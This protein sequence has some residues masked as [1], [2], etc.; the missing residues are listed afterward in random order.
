V[1]AAG[2]GSGSFGRRAYD[3]RRIH[4]GDTLG[5]GEVGLQLGL[6]RQLFVE[7]ALQR[8]RLA[9]TRF[10]AGEP[11]GCV[12]PP[13]RMV[14]DLALEVIE[15]VFK[16]GDQ[17]ERGQVILHV[18]VMFVVGAL[19]DESA[20]AALSTGIVPDAAGQVEPADAADGTVARVAFQHRHA[21]LGEQRGP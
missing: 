21:N 11:R 2:C 9:K 18:D 10:V 19:Q 20:G 12:R 15:H 14:L 16:P 1:A 6:P 17:A 8:K 7:F 5:P 13:S 3:V 4:S